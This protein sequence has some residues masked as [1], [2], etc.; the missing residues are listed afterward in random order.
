MKAIYGSDLITDESGDRYVLTIRPYVDDD[1]TTQLL[2]SKLEVRGPGFVTVLASWC[3]MP[4]VSFPED[5]PSSSPPVFQIRSAA[6][7]SQDSGCTYISGQ[8]HPNC[9]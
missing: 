1:D 3:V 6:D 9:C 7:L 8:E 4:Q 2:V 5:Y